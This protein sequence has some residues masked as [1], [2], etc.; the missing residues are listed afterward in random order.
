MGLLRALADQ[1]RRVQ[2]FKCGPDYIDTAF[3]RQAAGRESV[4]LDSFMM[5]RPH[6]QHIYNRYAREAE[7]LVTEGVMGLYDGYDRWHGSSYEVAQWTQQPVVLIVNAA[8]TAYSVAATIHGFRSLRPDVQLAGVVFNRVA[9][10]TTPTCRPPAR[11][12][13]CPPSAT[14]SANRTW[15]CPPATLASPWTTG[16]RW[17]TSSAG[18][19]RL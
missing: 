11:T 13:M 3:H 14:F 16:N 12:S 8:S 6:V 18:P 10:P 1:G 17:T 9:S 15:R 5:S 2:P 7:V 4:N 19:P